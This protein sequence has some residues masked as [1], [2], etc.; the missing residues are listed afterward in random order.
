[1]KTARDMHRFEGDAREQGYALIAGI[2]EAGRGPL[3]GPV[4]AAAVILPPDYD[5]SRITDSKALTAR[6][7]ERLYD[8]IQ[9]KAMAIGIGVM[10]ADEIDRLNILQ[11]TL[12]AMQEAVQGLRPAPDFLLIDG[13]SRIPIPIPQQTIVRGDS[14]SI[15]IAAAS[16]I[17]KVSRDRT[18]EI[19][20]RQFPH[21]NFGKNK[22]YGTR[23]H[24]EAIVRYGRCK[25]HRNSFKVAGIDDL[26]ATAELGF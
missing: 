18:M 22:G 7:R 10:E 9:D 25:I 2:D 12:S 4:V 16:I 8:V 17:A 1:M 11:A 13:I 14:S 24:R 5:D 15:S 6:Q 23:E 3:A 20:H 19:Y 26:P 21:Y